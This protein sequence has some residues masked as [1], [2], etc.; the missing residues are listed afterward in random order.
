MPDYHYDE[1]SN[2]NKYQLGCPM[3]K[4]IQGCKQIKTVIIL[5][6]L[7]SFWSLSNDRQ[8]AE[9]HPLNNGYSQLKVQQDGVEY[10][11]FIPEY[12]LKKYDANR[13]GSLSEEETILGAT[14]LES[15]LKSKV[16]LLQ[17][18]EPMIFSLRSMERT[19]NETIPGITFSLFYTGKQPVTGFTVEYELLFDQ[20]DPDH[21]NFAFILDGEDM[22][23]AVFDTAH[24]VYHYESLR[25][26]SRAA[27]LWNY[28]MLGIEHIWL[29]FDHLLF[30]FSLLLA[31]TRYRDM[32]KIVTAFTAAH[33][34]TLLLASLGYV[35]VN[36]VWIEAAIAL[37][38]CYVAVENIVAN[39]HGIR[40]ALTFIFGLVHGLGFAGA[41]EEIG[42]PKRYFLSSLLSFNLGVEI[43]Q[44]LVVFVSLPLLLWLQKLKWHRTVVI[45]GSAL[46]CFR[47]LWWLLERTGIIPGGG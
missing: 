39:K 1:P 23:Q 31:A 8:A 27:V 30:L 11:L 12:S 42:L 5:L 38:I 2:N 16:R 44:L 36:P 4:V 47:A 13:D 40:G 41:L 6:I 37:S 45:A 19:V 33:S 34:I 35:R 28:F 29:G 3:Y 14:E 9:A 22:D 10:E 20:E 46:I 17:N 24:R 7:A 26:D 43:G 21:L 25:P 15:S 18:A 32:V